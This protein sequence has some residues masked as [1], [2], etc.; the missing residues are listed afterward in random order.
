MFL[1]NQGILS[2]G[3]DGLMR[4]TG[5]NIDFSKGGIEITPIVPTG[6]LTTSNIY[7]PD[8]AL[9]DEYWGLGQQVF[10]SSTLMGFFGNVLFVTSPTHNVQPFPPGIAQI[11]I[12]NP[13]YSFI[14]NVQSVQIVVTN[15][16]GSLTNVSNIFV[17]T[18]IVRQAAF[19]GGPD[20]STNGLD[21]GFSVAIRYYPSTDVL[22]PMRTITVELVN[23]ATN[24]VT[25]QPIQTSL[26][27]KDT[28]ASEPG[29]I[30]AINSQGG[31]FR[32]NNYE[33]SRVA[34]AE[35]TG[36]GAGLT[37]LTNSLF[38]NA[39]IIGRFVTN[40]YAGYGVQVDNLASRPVTP[41]SDITNAPGR[42]EIRADSINLS[43]TRMR[44]EGLTMVEARH[45]VTST[46][47]LVDCQNL[48]YV[49]GS[50][51]GNVRVQSLVK[52]RTGRVSGDI[53]IYSAVWTNSQMFINTNYGAPTNIP[54]FN[55]ITNIATVKIHVLMV[56][57]SFLKSTLPVNVY[58]LRLSGTNMVVSDQATII[59]SLLF[60]GD[61]FLLEGG[62]FLTNNLITNTL[63]GF[64]AANA[65]NLKNF[66]NFGVFSASNAVYF[67]TDTVHPY[68]T[69]INGGTVSAFSQQYSAEA[70]EN[71]GLLLTSGSLGVRT[72]SGK[73]EGG[74]SSCSGDTE[75]WA[76]T[77]KLNHYQISTIGSL[78]FSVTNALFDNGPASAN[79]LF[80][81]GGC[82]LSM[83]PATGDLLGTTL[84]S[85]A[86]MF[87]DAN[88]YWAAEDRGA[89]S[90]G[91]LNNVA[92]GKLILHT[93]TYGTIVFH[94]VNASSAIYV[95]QLDLSNLTDYQNQIQIDPG[96]VVYFA[97]SKGVPEEQL[98]GQFN[99]QMRWV[100]S[101]AGPNSGV[102]VVVNGTQTIRVNRALRNSQ[103]IDSDADGIPN[104][105]DLTPFDGVIISKVQLRQTAPNGLE[106]SWL[107]AA[108]A[109]YK[110]E[111]TTSYSASPSWQSLGWVTNSFGTTNTV[112]F[113]D[114]NV[115]MAG[116]HRYYRVSYQP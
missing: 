48:S 28:I 73:L 35:F 54:P 71:Y 53:F 7:F 15:P 43:Q 83:K 75:F 96:F 81:A 37:G 52:A 94:T 104:Y 93:A 98:D 115:P 86:T 21:G 11:T 29:A 107:A 20:V 8:V 59:N 85:T 62:I 63:T 46:N 23:N 114:S 50:T 4:I 97:S 92:L 87:L 95:D 22:N 70:F 12:F 41:W 14:T 67:G 57:R 91:F 31:G 108:G 9:Y 1:Y 5:T 32:P 51:N 78:N 34:P 44:G 26:Y 66:T 56:D 74:A 69:F 90:A 39:D 100:Q 17:P 68:K 61:N 110:V 55:L 111:F 49:L 99:G 116:T 45:L 16:P 112:T 80:T 6:T 47:A 82:S 40:G 106:L 13:D 36:G 89:T 2:V 72:G 76:N 3:V 60:N 79:Q 10:D 38:Y 58:N 84:D 25:G 33:V 18:N 24:V 65:P 105:W 109:A 27:V 88:H 103:L 19:V 101:Y 102:D 42:V 64:S 77:L 30:L 113:V